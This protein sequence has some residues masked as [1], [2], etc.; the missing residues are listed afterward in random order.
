MGR[1]PAFF[2]TPGRVDPRVAGPR[3]RGRFDEMDKAEQIHGMIAG[4][5]EAMG[6][7]IV[8]VQIGGGHR[9]KLQ[10][11]AERLDDAAM[12]AENC[13]EISRAV[14]A[15]LDV[16]DPIPGAYTLE[17]SSPGIDR[18]LTRPADFNRFAGQEARVEM[19]QMIDG[20]R[21]FQ[22]TLLGL[23]GDSVRLKLPEGETV[24]LSLGDIA[25]AKLVLT[26][27]LLAG[28]ARGQKGNGKNG[29]ASS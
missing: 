20:R 4:S 5:L 22:G 23:E 8:R 26:D 2:V 19:R 27:T 10:I 13:A 7:G 25:K 28:A 3:R 16:E 1:R 12:S 15:V 9:P 11:M 17:V 21:R 6:Y 29:K 24:A 14:S 18:P